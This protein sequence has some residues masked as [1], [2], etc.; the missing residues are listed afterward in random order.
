M[1]HTPDFSGVCIY[2][3]CFPKVERKITYFYEEEK[4]AA[5]YGRSMVRPGYGVRGQSAFAD[6]YSG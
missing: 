4:C 2:K 6:P 1:I 3:N 5:D